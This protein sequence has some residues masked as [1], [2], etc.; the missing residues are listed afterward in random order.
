MREGGFI[1]SE[2]FSTSNPFGKPAFGLLDKLPA[3]RV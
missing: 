3:D 2:R 1:M